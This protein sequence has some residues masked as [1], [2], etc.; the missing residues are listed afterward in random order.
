MRE[1]SVLNLDE[2]SR[3]PLHGDFYVNSLGAHLKENHL[4][5][6]RPHRH[7]FYALF[8]FVKGTGTHEVDFNRYTVRPGSF[9]FL[10]PG[11]THSWELSDDVEGYVFFHTQSFVDQ[12]LTH[13][14]LREYPIFRSLLYGNHVLLPDYLFGEVLSLFETLL[15]ESKGNLW[16][17]SIMMLIQLMQ[18]YVIVNRFALSQEGGVREVKNA[19]HAHVQQ[20]EDLVELYFKENKTASFYAEQMKVSTRHLNR[21]C[22]ELL[23]KTTT[24]ILM[25]R[26]VLEAKRYLIYT[27]KGLDEIAMELGY[28]DY[29]YFSKVFKKQVGETP[30]QFL[31][32]YS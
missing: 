20:F 17:Q 28:E 4:R 6:E 9:F 3:R 15:V 30:K 19:Y 13:E 26:V 24:T 11:Q 25:N 32:R 16:N 31:N 12:F 5:I 8:L 18:V 27:R 10:A 22:M 29:S 21:V 2:L 7:D 1:I 23:G 14:Y